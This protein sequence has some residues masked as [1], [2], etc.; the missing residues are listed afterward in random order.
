MSRGNDDRVNELEKEKNA[1][2]NEMSDLKAKVSISSS[3]A[4]GLKDQLKDMKVLCYTCVCTFEHVCVCLVSVYA[5]ARVKAIRL[6]N[7]IHSLLVV[8][9][10]TLGGTGRAAGL[11]QGTVQRPKLGAAEV[12]EREGPQG[13]RAA[14][15]RQRAARADCRLRAALG[16]PA[17]HRDGDRVGVG[18]V[19]PR[20]LGAQ[21]QAGRP[22]GAYR[23]AEGQ[24]D[25]GYLQC[26]SEGLVEAYTTVQYACL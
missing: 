14:D 10:T 3:E 16:H 17:A 9:C 11:A 24:K 2:L 8:F 18:D 21:E 4:D 23:R 19:G 20:S 5:F 22:K 1:L 25:D 13:A 26:L 7:L 6:R 12:R 15:G